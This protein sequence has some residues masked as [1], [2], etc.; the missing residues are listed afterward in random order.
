M[1]EKAE[2]T[3]IPLSYTFSFINALLIIYTQIC[4]KS[5]NNQERL[6]KFRIFLLIVCD[7]FSII[8]ELIYKNYLNVVFYELLAT[9]LY[10]LQFFIY[11]SFIV[12]TLINCYKID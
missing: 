3:S 4:L 1:E 2:N 6:L 9:F 8:F 10:S 7:S 11:I 12:E 5:K